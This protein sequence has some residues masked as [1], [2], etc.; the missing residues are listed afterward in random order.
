MPLARLAVSMYLAYLNALL[1][2]HE[3]CNALPHLGHTYFGAYIDDFQLS[4]MGWY[5]VSMWH[6]VDMACALS[7]DVVEDELLS[8]LHPDKAQVTASTP[9]LADSVVRFLGS[10]GGQAPVAVVETLG[11]D[12]TAG[13]MVGR[14][15]H[16]S[17]QARCPT[18][19]RR[20][21]KARLKVKRAVRLMRQ[22]GSSIRRVV[23]QNIPATITYGAAVVGCPPATMLAAPLPAEGASTSLYSLPTWT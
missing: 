17:F 9:Q 22:V 8:C 13:R 11:I 14:R 21:A 19:V 15:A 4:V 2:F 5:Q 12:T 18:Q 3:K 16:P 6:S 1:R 10:I 20:V 7:N 23:R